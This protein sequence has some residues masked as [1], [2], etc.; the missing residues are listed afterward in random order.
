MASFILGAIV[1]PV[2]AVVI[3][4]AFDVP[5]F[6][7]HSIDL[8]VFVRDQDLLAEGQDFKPLDPLFLVSNLDQC[9]S[10]NML[11]SSSC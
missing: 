7:L 9:S 8:N 4:E 6:E 3:D 11:L 10:R 1:F 2:F 5:A